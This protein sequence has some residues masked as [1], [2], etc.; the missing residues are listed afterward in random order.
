MMTKIWHASA[1]LFLF[2]VRIV[3]HCEIWEK[4]KFTAVKTTETNNLFTREREEHEIKAIKTRRASWKSSLNNLGTRLLAYLTR[5]LNSKNE[6]KEL[7]VCTL[8]VNTCN[9]LGS[10]IN[11]VSSFK[12]TLNCPRVKYTRTDVLLK[13]LSQSLCALCPLKIKEDRSSKHND[14]SLQ[15]NGTF[16]TKSTH[17]CSLY[18][19]MDWWG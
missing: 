9:V 7:H 14:G 17:E 2:Y 6:A 3:I 15:E 1:R 12:R 11:E 13:A 19:V 8:F 5:Q 10:F 18:L 16:M 4:G